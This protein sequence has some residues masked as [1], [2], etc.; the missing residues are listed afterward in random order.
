MNTWLHSISKDVYDKMIGNF[1]I[2]YNTMLEQG[3]I[4]EEVFGRLGFPKELKVHGN[5]T[6]RDAGIYQEIFSNQKA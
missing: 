4:S 6:S 3:R 5:E 2:L 1:S